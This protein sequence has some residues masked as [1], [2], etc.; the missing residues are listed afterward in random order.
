MTG[1][2]VSG[3]LKPIEADRIFVQQ[4]QKQQPEKKIM[5]ILPRMQLFVERV[6]AE[7]KKKESLQLFCWFKG[8]EYVKG[9]VG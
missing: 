2:R 8:E 4:Q 5:K 6:G 7:I 1:E 9:H 3:K